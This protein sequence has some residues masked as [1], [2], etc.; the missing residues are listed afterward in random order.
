MP[1]TV[2]LSS[3]ELEAEIAA[4]YAMGQSDER[5]K[6]RDKVIDALTTNRHDTIERYLKTTGWRMVAVKSS[7]TEWLDARESFRVGLP[8]RI[9]PRSWMT[10][11]RGLAAYHSKSPQAIQADILSYGRK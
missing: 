7:G 11:L 2:T 4:A 6:Q 3:A 8:T 10:L 5:K 1:D 9:T